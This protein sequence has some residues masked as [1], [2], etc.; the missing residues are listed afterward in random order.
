[1]QQS[2]KITLGLGIA[3]DFLSQL[4]SLAKQRT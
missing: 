2:S 1:M 4:A 3:A